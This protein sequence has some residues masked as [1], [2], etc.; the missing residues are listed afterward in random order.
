MRRKWRIAAHDTGR[1]DSLR[2]AAGLPAIVAQLLISR[3]VYDPA[4]AQDFLYPKL[5]QLRD[6]FELP[7]VE[8]AV[9]V[10]TDAIS[11]ERRIVIFGDYDA[12]G[13]TGTSILYR[14]LTLLGAN[15]GYYVPNRLDEG[16]GLNDGALEKLAKAGA[17]PDH[18]G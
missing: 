10:I 17:S 11:A 7:G 6:P 18:H 13:I 8:S 14:C 9:G 16:Y 3:G 5:T 2:Q 12:D 4:L 15:V 1:I